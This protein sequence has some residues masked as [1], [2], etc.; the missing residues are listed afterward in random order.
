MSVSDIRGI[1]VLRMIVVNTNHAWPVTCFGVKFY[2]TVQWAAPGF[3]PVNHFHPYPKWVTDNDK[4]LGLK[5]PTLLLITSEKHFI[6]RPSE[7]DVGFLLKRFLLKLLKY[8]DAYF[9]KKK[10]S[11]RL[12]ENIQENSWEWVLKVLF[13]EWAK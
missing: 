1:L 12:S 11:W 8:H 2:T 10:N 7:L 13:N 5:Y 3:V 9:A 6:F 4:L